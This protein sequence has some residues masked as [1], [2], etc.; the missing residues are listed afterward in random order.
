MPNCLTLSD[1]KVA[2]NEVLKDSEHIELAV[3]KAIYKYDRQLKAEIEIMCDKN[4]EIAMGAH[5]N[6]CPGAHP[7]FDKKPW[8]MLIPLAVD[9]I[10]KRVVN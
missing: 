2:M 7:K 6:T 4:V 9:A 5:K 1:V 8:Y 10:M 3:T